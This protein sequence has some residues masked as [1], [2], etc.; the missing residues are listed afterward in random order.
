MIITKNIR[1]IDANGFLYKYYS[2]YYLKDNQRDLKRFSFRRN[3]LFLPVGIEPG[4][5]V[6]LYYR[7]RPASAGFFNHE[8]LEP[9]IRSF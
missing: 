2:L 8:A 5:I 6:N 1:R 3:K 7:L 9:K 4:T